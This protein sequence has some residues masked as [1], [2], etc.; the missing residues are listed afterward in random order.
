MSIITDVYAR[1]VL[2]SRGNP[3][4]EVE[5]YTESGAFGRGMVPS[6]ASTGEHEAVEL[7]DGDKSRYLGLGT[8]K[9]VD[10][11]NNVIADAIIGYDVRDQQAID[12]AMIALDGT[13]N[14]G[15]LG[16]NAILGVSIAVARAAADYLEIPLYSYLGGFNTKVLPTPM[17]NII[18]GGS[19]SDAPIAFQEFMILPVGAPT[20]KEGLRWGA[21]VFHALKKILKSRGLVTAVGDEGGFA[22]KFEGTEDGVETIIEAIEAAGYEAGENGIMIG[23]DCASS[24]FYDK[25][26]KV[27][28]YTKF[29]GEGAAV[30]TSAEQIDYLEELVNKYPIITIEDGMDENDWDGWK[31]LTE[32]LGKRVQLVGD[33]FF[34]TNTDYL[35][36]GIKEGAANSILIK[37]NQIGTLTETF[38]AIE[39]AKEAGYTAVVSHRSGETEDSTIADIAVATNAGQIKTG[40]LSRTDRIAKYNQ[41]LRIEDQLGEVAVYK[42]LNSFYNLK[43]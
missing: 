43:K 4:L 35:A 20:F 16:A 19:H 23:F 39:M 42:G 38:E 2:D 27:Y 28:D 3:T 1:E 21:E 5:V 7:R 14:K 22:P 9:A 13:P 17:M 40:S 34:V 6:G 30:R 18:N 29:E 37:V 31:A 25:E 33:D 36:R 8:Q 10:N 11:V 24:E 26:R 32:R 15:K 41:L 12:R